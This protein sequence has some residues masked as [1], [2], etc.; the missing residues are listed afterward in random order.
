MWRDCW[1][2]RGRRGHWLCVQSPLGETRGRA[3]IRGMRSLAAPLALCLLLS[4]ALA[5]EA[6]PDESGD[7]EDGFSLLGE[8]M[9]LLLRGLIDEMEPAM[10][11][12]GDAMAELQPALR[13]LLAQVDDLRNY[14]APERLPN[15]DILIRRKPDAPPLPAPPP[16]AAPEA[17]A[18]DL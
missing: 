12:M 10:R 16:K 8:G 5:Q 15:G 2:L 11:D 18:I 9:N 3:Y 1:R 13:D 7:V 17:P 14:Q 6:P 4:P